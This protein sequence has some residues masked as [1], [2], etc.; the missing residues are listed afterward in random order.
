M[1]DP[2]LLRDHDSVA[3]VI[4]RSGSSGG[5]RIEL[6]FEGSGQRAVECREIVV[7]ADGGFGR[8]YRA[9][10]GETRLGRSRSPDRRQEQRR[11]Q[12]GCN[13]VSA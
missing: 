6:A 12:R 1:G 11:R 2:G 4:V 5:N 3:V 8:R 7:F 13:K 10:T 9:S